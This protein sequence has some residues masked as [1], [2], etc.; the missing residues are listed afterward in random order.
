MEGER[1]NVW[2]FRD[3]SRQG[4]GGLVVLERKEERERERKSRSFIADGEE[5]RLSGIEVDQEQRK[6]SLSVSKQ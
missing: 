5:S 6:R 2:E 3:D 1:R 4:R